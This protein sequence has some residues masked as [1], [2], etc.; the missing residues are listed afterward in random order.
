MQIWLYLV[1]KLSDQQSI[2]QICKIPLSNLRL[3]LEC[4]SATPLIRCV[5]SV[6]WIKYLQKSKGPEKN[7]ICQTYVTCSFLCGQKHITLLWISSKFITLT[8]WDP[9]I[10]EDMHWHTQCRGLCPAVVTISVQ[11]DEP[12]CTYPETGLVPLRIQILTKGHCH[13]FKPLLLRLVLQPVVLETDSHQ[14]ECTNVHIAVTNI[15]IST[16]P[17]FA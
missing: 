10:R 12:K 14:D 17:A 7:I 8:K 1:H 13:A 15:N 11:R 6:A 4:I 16:S 2:G 5:W 9:K 3:L